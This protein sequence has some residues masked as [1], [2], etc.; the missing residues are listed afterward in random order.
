MS[1]TNHNNKNESADGSRRGGDGKRWLREI[2]EG[3]YK[4]F[5]MKVQFSSVQFILFH[6]QSIQHAKTCIGKEHRRE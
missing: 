5:L 2:E 4:L 1:H 6:T 3:K